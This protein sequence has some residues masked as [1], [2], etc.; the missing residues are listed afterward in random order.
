MRET[1]RKNMA[2]ALE[3]E[4]ASARFHGIRRDYGAPDVVRLRG[5]V[6]VVPEPGIAAMLMVGVGL[7]GRTAR[8][9]KRQAA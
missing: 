4:W 1:G 9:G 3:A 7:L 5:S 8:R 6:L 2:H